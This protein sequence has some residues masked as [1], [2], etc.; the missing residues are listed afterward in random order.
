MAENIVKSPGYFD[1]EITLAN[2]TTSPSGIPA[3]VI[4]TS[5]KG[6]AFIPITVGSFS[7]YVVRFGERDPKF[8]GPYAIN[9]FLKNRFSATFIRVLGAGAN[10]TTAN[11]D[12]TRTQ[13]T[14]VNAGWKHTPA[15]T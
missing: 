6:P 12:T 10:T 2:K 3:G 15:I 4:S 11:F 8:L 1:R 13:G 9:E 14:V 5:L 7:D